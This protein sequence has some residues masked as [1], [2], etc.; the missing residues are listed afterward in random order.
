MAISQRG[1]AFPD[2]GARGEIQRIPQDWVTLWTRWIRQGGFP[3][4]PESEEQDTEQEQADHRNVKHGRE[5]ER[6]GMEGCV[7]SYTDTPAAIGCYQCGERQILWPCET[8]ST[9]QYY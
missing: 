8:Q 5:G 4:L 3:P 7:G 1:E 2:R 9:S 6:G